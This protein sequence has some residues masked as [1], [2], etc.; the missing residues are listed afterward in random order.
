[1][2]AGCA[3]TGSSDCALFAVELWLKAGRARDARLTPLPADWVAGHL[4]MIAVGL[5][6]RSL[7]HFVPASF[8]MLTKK[9][10]HD[11]HLGMVTRLA[12]V[13][14]RRQQLISAA[15]PPPSPPSGLSSGSSAPLSILADPARQLTVADLRHA[16]RHPAPP[17]TPPAR[18]PGNAAAAAG[19]EAGRVLHTWVKHHRHLRAVP[20]ADGEPTVALMLLWEADHGKTFPCRAVD[21]VRRLGVFAKKFSEAVAADAE[22]S[23]WLGSKKLFAQ[24]SPGIPAAKYVKWSVK[25]DSTVG[26]PFLAAW[27]AYLLTLVIPAATPPAL[28]DAAAAAPE[29]AAPRTNRPRAQLGSKRKPAGD[30][31]RPPDNSKRTRIERLQAAKAA[32][33]ANAFTPVVPSSSSSSSSSAL[34]S[35]GDGGLPPG[36]P[37]RAGLATPGAIT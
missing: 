6:P 17:P 31:K 30:A 20:I 16:E 23:Q 18:R 11:F 4:Y 9:L 8:D 36:V 25:I 27:K 7:T 19:L 12:E 33:A 13:L 24:L 5:I 2:V 35:S 15:L 32:M 22:L 14:R 10:L 28:V 1:M 26:E 3:G 21:F 34:P 37:S 29:P